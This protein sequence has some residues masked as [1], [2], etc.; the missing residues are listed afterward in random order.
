MVLLWQAPIVEWYSR[1]VPATRLWHLARSP[2]YY[3]YL[4]PGV[5]HLVVN[6]STAI[7][8]VEGLE[9]D[10]ALYE[11]LS[12]GAARVDRE[13]MSPEGLAD[14]LRQALEAIRRR[15][16]YDLLLDDQTALLALLEETGA[17][18][19]F[20]ELEISQRDQQ[21]TGIRT[22]RI[23]VASTPLP[24]TPRR[25]R[26]AAAAAMP[27]RRRRDAATPPKVARRGDSIPAQTNTGTA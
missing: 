22:G 11:R 6:R 1:G 5:T 17:C 18:E 20:V 2:R 25:L 10:P 21:Y 27:R 16:R 23:W 12:N 7:Q 24:P 4:R 15:V 8:V 26:H 3:P 13:V 14:Y 19:K 9:A